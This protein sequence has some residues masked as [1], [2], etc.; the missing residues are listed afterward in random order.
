MKRLSITLLVATAP[1][2][3]AQTPETNN[4]QEVKQLASNVAAEKQAT[5]PEQKKSEK[6]KEEAPKK[7]QKT[8]GSVTN[9]MPKRS[10]KDAIQELKE[11][12]K[13]GIVIVDFWQDM[14]PPCRQIAPSIDAFAKQYPHE[15]YIKVDVGTY[16]EFTKAFG[17]R[18]VPRVDVY[19]DGKLKGSLGGGRP[20]DQLRAGIERLIKQ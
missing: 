5:K 10:G 9:F 14:C 19:V 11:M 8:W 16:R 20:K 1:F 7:Q 13:E 12:T 3:C 18:G 15:R 17:I 6:T 2:M 4:K